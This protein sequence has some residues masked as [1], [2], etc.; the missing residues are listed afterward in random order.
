MQTDLLYQGW[1]QDF[2]TSRAVNNTYRRLIEPET[3]GIQ[4]SE[5]E[6]QIQARGKSDMVKAVD[7]GL[8]VTES[9]GTK[10]DKQDTSS[11]SGN[12]T[13]QVVDADIGPVND[14]EHLWRKLKGNIVDSK[15]AK[16]S[17]LG[18]PP[19]QP[20]RNHLVVRQ[21]NAF[22]S[23]RPRISRQRFAS[24]VDEKNDLYLP[25]VRESA[26]AKPHHVNAPSSSRNS[27]KESYGSNDMAHTYFL[28]KGRKK[29]QDKT[30][31][32]N[33]KD[34]ASTRALL[35]SYL[36]G[37][38]NLDHNIGVFLYLSVV[39]ECQMVLNKVNSRAKVQSPKIRNNNP[40]EPGITLIVPGRRL[41]L[42]TQV[43]EFKEFK[44]DEHA[45]KDV[46]TNQ[47][48]PRL[49][50]HLND[51][52]TMIK[53]RMHRFDKMNLSILSVHWYKT[54]LSLPHAILIMKICIHFNQQSHE[55]QW[56]KDH[57]LEQVID[58]PTNPV[59]T[60]QQL[61]T[62]PEMCMFALTVSTEEPKNSKEA[63]AD[64]AW[65]EAMQDEL[66]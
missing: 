4:K 42:L 38:Q 52:T 19:L 9:S 37:H 2:E 14:E 16:A 6:T 3:Q 48:R 27:H 59:Q 35:H 22:T 61:A 64:S 46:W 55:Y 50:L 62:D 25:N 5:I 12:Y 23:E 31:I 60:R 63:M 36:L 33:H 66:H 34:M 32:P 11:S 47:F 56:T 53:Q 43:Q 28:E 15:F 57:P 8:V 40:V 65:I 39:V 58:N 7:A 17:I 1:Q 29:T 18:K 49:V 45:S 26:P 54:L 41:V 10:P 51:K 13:T 21:P 30:R 44:S 20:S 24:Q